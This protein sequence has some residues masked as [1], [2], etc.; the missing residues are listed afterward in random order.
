MYLEASC[1]GKRFQI[2]LY[3]INIREETIG[4]F[5]QFCLSSTHQDFIPND[6]DSMPKNAFLDLQFWKCQVGV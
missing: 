1:Y 6:R 4:F 2:F 5:R 3:D